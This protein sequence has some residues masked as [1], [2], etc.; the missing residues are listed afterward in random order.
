MVVWTFQ[1]TPK[2]SKCSPGFEEKASVSSCGGGEEESGINRNRGEHM[3][4]HSIFHEADNSVSMAFCHHSFW[5]SCIWV[6][7]ELK[8]TEHICRLLL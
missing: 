2:F 8:I 5:P 3:K 6:E 1:K 7:E 4:S